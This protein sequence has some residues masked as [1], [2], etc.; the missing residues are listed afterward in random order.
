MP[1]WKFADNQWDYLGDNGQGSTNQYADRDLFGWGTSGFNHGGVCWQPWS[2]SQIYSDYFIGGLRSAALLRSADWGYNAICNGGNAIG[3]W[4]T[5]SRQQWDYLLDERITNSGIRYVLS[6]VNGVKGLLALPDDWNGQLYSLQNPNDFSSQFSD[7]TI[8]LEN[9]NSIFEP[10]GAVFL[11]CSGQRT[12]TEVS[13][14][15]TE[16]CYWSTTPIPNLY[17]GRCAYYVEFNDGFRFGG[18]ASRYIG[19][20]VRL[21]QDY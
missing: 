12:G 5:L 10:N 16:G 4:H 19:A 17:D 1:Y 14:V 2:T 15:S 8:S 13:Y 18:F 7:N 6:I 9:W 20:S 21:V 3:V 11:P